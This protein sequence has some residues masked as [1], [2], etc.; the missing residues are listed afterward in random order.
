VF[1]YMIIYKLQ[2]ARYL[3]FRA[4]SIF[5]QESRSATVR[6]NTSELELESGSTQK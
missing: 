1:F 5:A 4:A 2:R 3:F 6:L